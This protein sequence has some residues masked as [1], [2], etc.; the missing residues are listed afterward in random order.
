MKK[1][2]NELEPANMHHKHMKFQ[3]PSIKY[4]FNKIYSTNKKKKY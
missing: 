2:N 4:L 3:F 1:V